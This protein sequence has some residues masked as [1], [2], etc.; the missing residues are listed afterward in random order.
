MPLQTLQDKIKWMIHY[1]DTTDKSCLQGYRISNIRTSIF[2]DDFTQESK[3]YAVSLCIGD[4]DSYN[5]VLPGQHGLY[6]TKYERNKH[7]A[8]SKRSLNN[9]NNFIKGTVQY[10]Y[11]NQVQQKDRVVVLSNKDKYAIGLA[12]ESIEKRNR[13]NNVLH[14]V[15]LSKR[16]VL[17]QF[18]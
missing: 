12:G 3:C 16:V 5:R 7:W 2:V 1:M 17:Y 4:T 11:Q 14:N 10:C 13:F 15:R 18:H 9:I 6:H 8:K